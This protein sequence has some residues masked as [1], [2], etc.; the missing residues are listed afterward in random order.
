MALAEAGYPRERKGRASTGEIYVD[1]V[2]Y[3]VLVKAQRLAATAMGWDFEINWPGAGRET[4]VSKETD[5][6]H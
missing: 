2:P 1:P 6:D 3:D 5:A 4:T